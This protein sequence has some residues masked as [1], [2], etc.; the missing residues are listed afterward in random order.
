MIDYPT[1]GADIIE[2]QTNIGD[3]YRLPFA[4]IRSNDGA[5]LDHHFLLN[6]TYLVRGLVAFWGSYF[7]WELNWRQS[8]D[9]YLKVV[10]PVHRPHAFAEID[11]ESWGGKITGD[12]SAEVVATWDRIVRHINGLRRRGTRRIMLARDRRRVILYGNQYDLAAL[13]PHI[14]KRINYNIA[15]YGVALDQAQLRANG[16][17]PKRVVLHQFSMSYPV[18]PFGSCDVNGSSQRVKKLASQLGVVVFKKWE[19]TR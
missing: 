8:V 4:I 10:F 11:L 18:E 17:D 6:L 15:D 2:F 14:D 16:I 13:A 5:Y 19:S 7:V 1:K 3:R 9:T 12:H